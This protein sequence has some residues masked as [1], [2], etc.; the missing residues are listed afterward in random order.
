LNKPGDSTDA[1]VGDGKLAF[2]LLAPSTA[3]VSKTQGIR[4]AFMAA[5]KSAEADIQIRRSIRA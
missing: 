3:G 5:W 2:G 4:L 1:G